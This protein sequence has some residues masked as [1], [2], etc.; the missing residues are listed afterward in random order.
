MYVRN[1]GIWNQPQWVQAVRLHGVLL[2]LSGDE[3][4]SQ[5][6]FWY[7]RW[8][9]VVQNSAGARLGYDADAT[10]A[11]FK[12]VCILRR[13]N[14]TC[15]MCIANGS[16]LLY[17]CSKQ[18]DLKPTSMC[19]SR[20]PSWRSTYVKWGRR[21]LRRCNGTCHKCIAN[22]RNLLYVCPHPRGTCLSSAWLF[23]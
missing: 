16:D 4:H 12:G 1:S 11:K 23:P 7:L 3:L 21:I 22:G 19:S 10:D 14:R 6:I 5:K 13:C 2:T 8:G 15:P 17:V 20:T 18:R 9:E